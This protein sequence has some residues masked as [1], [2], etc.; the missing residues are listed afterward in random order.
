MT[1]YAALTSHHWRWIFITAL[2]CFGF[3]IWAVRKIVRMWPER[4]ARERKKSSFQIRMARAF[5][6]F[7]AIP[8]FILASFSIFFMHIGVHTWF[9]RQVQIAVRGAEAIA[10]HY[11]KE[12]QSLI[13][14]SAKTLLKS[15]KPLLSLAI[16]SPGTSILDPSH[17]FKS[18]LGGNLLQVLNRHEDLQNISSM[19]FSAPLTAFS[20]ET[21][22]LRL[23]VHVLSIKGGWLPTLPLKMSDLNNAI[24]GGLYIRSTTNFQHLLAL[25]PLDIFTNTFILICRPIDRAILERVSD[26]NKAAKTYQNYLE[27]QKYWIPVSIALFIAFTLMLVLIAMIGGLSFAQQTIQPIGALIRA[28]EEVRRG[29]IPLIPSETMPATSEL[30]YL[31]SAFNSMSQEVGAKTKE[32]NTANDHLYNRNLFIESVLEGASSGVMSLK[33]DATIVFFN[34]TAQKLLTPMGSLE[35]E[36]LLN[37]IPEFQP[38]FTQALSNSE[39]AYSDSITLIRGHHVRTFRLHI[40]WLATTD[41]VV[42]TMDDIST[43]IAAQK[44]SAWSDVAC[45]IAHEI[46]N[47]LTPIALSAERLRRRYIKEIQNEPEIFQDCID[48]IIRQVHH[49]GD[50]ISEFSD[51]ARLPQP[52]LANTDLN[53]VLIQIIVL[54]QQAYPGISFDYTRQPIPV[55]A[56]AQQIEQVFTNVFK[57]AVESIEETKRLDGCI[58][59]SIKENKDWI[60]I[61]IQDNGSGLSSDKALLLCEAYQTTKAQGM[62]LGLAIVQKIID[63]HGGLFSIRPAPHSDGACV[64]ISLMKNGKLR[65]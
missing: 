17:R 50:L 2:V 60:M 46:K 57:N 11:L 56:D 64:T 4:H 58:T 20:N 16:D 65:P 43:L 8:C 59:V 61:S 15:L 12:Q 34:T 28:S 9:D 39:T 19:I 10:Q 30:R 38:L 27:T 48:T 18:V 54:H 40:Q 47:P 5:A 35:E 53:I 21:S 23:S 7:V 24:N 22:S 14:F 26:T 55:H 6:L 31:M 29:Q 42:A 3:G 13:E 36:N 52:R 25:I 44:K 45:R 51:F 37:I 49:I 1:A 62:G 33:P 63:D 32:L 41:T